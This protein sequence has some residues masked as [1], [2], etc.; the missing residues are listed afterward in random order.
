MRPSS[1][2][3]HAITAGRAVLACS[4]LALALF[5]GSLSETEIYK[6]RANQEITRPLVTVNLRAIGSTD[7]DIASQ[8]LWG[9]NFNQLSIEQQQSV[10]QIVIDEELLLQRAERLQLVSTD[11]GLRK[12]AVAAA[13]DQVVNN[14]LAQ[15]TTDKALQQF[16]LDHNSLFETAEKLALD[17]LLINSP[18]QIQQAN[19]MLASGQTLT[20]IAEHLNSDYLL[21]RSLLPAHVLYRQLGPSMAKIV[22][23][24]EEGEHSEPIQRVEGLYIFHLSHRQ[25]PELPPY[26]SIGDSVALEYQRR[27]REQALDTKLSQLRKR[28]DITIAGGQ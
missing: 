26:Q 7:A 8:R 9:L 1:L 6:T 28:A 10:V 22:Q 11:P 23:A 16:Y 24:L 15:P 14:F 4:G 27:G 19:A 18:I 12:A 17:A 25:A 2:Q 3:C 13:I 20:Q 21:P 5:A